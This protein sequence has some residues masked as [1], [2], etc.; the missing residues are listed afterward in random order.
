MESIKFEKSCGIIVFKDEKVLMVHQ[1]N[2]I[3]GFPKGH[4]EENETEEETALREVYEETGIR[5]RIIPS[6]REVNTYSP[7][8]N[9]MKDVIF[10]VGT[11]L[12][13]NINMQLTEIDKC[14]FVPIKDVT[15]KLSHKEL[16]DIY[17]KSLDFI[18]N[19]L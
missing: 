3:W 9:V 16:I 4:V 13:T 7:R 12:D 14:E 18:K 8:E 10:F 11:C 5:A 2:D 17:N 1:I 19:V 6:F 15:E